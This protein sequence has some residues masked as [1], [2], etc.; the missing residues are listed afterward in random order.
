MANKVEMPATGSDTTTETST[1]QKKF[2]GS[3]RSV[4]KTIIIFIAILVFGSIAFITTLAVM[5]HVSS[6]RASRAEYE[7]LRVLAGEAESESGEFAV[8]PLSA[9]DIEMLQINPD[10]VGWLHIGGT[11]IDYPVVRGDDNEKYLD[12]SFYG[13]ESVTGALFMDF[14]NVGNLLSSSAEDS[15]PHI[16]IFGHNLQQGGM[17][18]D[19]RRFLKREFLEENNIITLTVNDEVMEFQIFSARLSD[20]EDPAYYINFGD[21]RSFPR[22]ANRIDAPLRANQIIT[23][24]TC[25]R[26]GSDDARIIVQGYRL[27]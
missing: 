15:V 27:A 25:V 2:V 12:T 17:F 14:R 11:G 20:I 1:S 10:Y 21:S 7:G 16:I 6:I 26:G 23:L 19:L 9:L 5:A 3:F 8:T 13:E 22:F 4:S 18:S 24:S